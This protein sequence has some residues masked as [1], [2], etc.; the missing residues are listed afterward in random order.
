MPSAAGK[1]ADISAFLGSAS[2]AKNGGLYNTGEDFYGNLSGKNNGAGAIELDASLGY[3]SSPQ[4]MRYTWYATGPKQG[5]TIS[6][7]IALPGGS[8]QQVWVEVVVRFSDD[9][10]ISNGYTGGAAYK[11]VHVNV[12]GTS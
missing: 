3:G 12:S 7:Q 9:F 6:R 5:G 2:D 11:F 10:K 1:K 4:S 8:A